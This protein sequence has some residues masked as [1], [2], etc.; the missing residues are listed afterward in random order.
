M[1]T[2]A[3][4]LLALSVAVAAGV[5]VLRDRRGVRALLEEVARR[6]KG[7]VVEGSWYEYPRLVLDVG[8]KPLRVTPVHGH[9]GPFMTAWLSGIE[10]CCKL[11]LRR[12]RAGIEFL[13]SLGRRA[14]ATGD[15]PFDRTFTMIADD[16]HAA[17]AL[18]TREVR[19]SLLAFDPRN[20][21]ELRLGRM[22]SW[23]AAHPRPELD[24]PYLDVTL[25]GLLP[26]I[27]D[28]ER[29]IDLVEEIEARLTQ[30][31]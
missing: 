15:E 16:G 25:D 30:L 22:R 11:E 21:I 1:P 2:W 3:L 19:S 23:Q 6:R 14:T 10:P 26:E 9:D 8:G 5:T 7:E 13:G 28:L 31:T 4:A 27:E 29:L 12:K 20:E 17:R 24:D 18:M